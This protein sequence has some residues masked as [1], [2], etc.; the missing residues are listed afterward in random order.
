M[1]QPILVG[2]EYA[3]DLIELGLSNAIDSGADRCII[4]FAALA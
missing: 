1:A 3:T 4:E 2:G